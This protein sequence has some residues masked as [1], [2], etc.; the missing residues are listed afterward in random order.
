MNRHRRRQRLGGRRGRRWQSAR[1]YPW[2]LQGGRAR[3]ARGRHCVG[4][5]VGS[6]VVGGVDEASDLEPK[7]RV[8]AHE[9]LHLPPFLLLRPLCLGKRIPRRLRLVS[10]QLRGSSSGV[11][12][13]EGACELREEGGLALL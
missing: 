9:L 4:A 8:L 3:S 5:A 2:R 6:G 13:V 12:L 10:L 1:L 11:P 7:V